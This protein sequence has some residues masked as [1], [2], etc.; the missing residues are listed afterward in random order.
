VSLTAALATNAFTN[1]LHQSIAD[2][3]IDLSIYNEITRDKLT[4]AKSYF[5]SRI[6]NV[7][8]LE[9]AYSNLFWR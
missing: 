8:T 9:E 3:T 4:K 7:P 1:G 6:F 2:K 5:D